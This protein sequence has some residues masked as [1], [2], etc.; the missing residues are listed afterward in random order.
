MKKAVI[1]IEKPQPDSGLQARVAELEG[2]LAAA[3]ERL[4]KLDPTP[5]IELLEPFPVD[6]DVF[7]LIDDDGRYPMK[8]AGYNHKAG[9]VL[10]MVPGNPGLRAFPIV[11][12]RRF[13]DCPRALP[14]SE[15]AYENVKDPKL[16]AEL[17]ERAAARLKDATAEPKGPFIPKQERYGRT[18]EIIP[19]VGSVYID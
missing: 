4:E 8:V 17:Q 5:K 15:R 2:R 3:E 16:R 14:T 1:E 9:H 12:V 13:Q 6:S 11:S 19:G 10:V 18:K 7:S